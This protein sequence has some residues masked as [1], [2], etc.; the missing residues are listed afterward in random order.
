MEIYIE[1]LEEGFV[2][3]NHKRKV[4]KLVKSLYGLKQAPKQWHEKFDK[5]M[6][7]NDFRINEC[8]KCVYVKGTEKGYVIVCLYVDDML[9]I[10]SNNEFIKATKKMLTS[11]FEMKDMGVADVILEV[12]PLYPVRLFV[13]RLSAPLRDKF[14]LKNSESNSR[15]GSLLLLSKTRT[16]QTIRGANLYLTASGEEA[17][18]KGVHE[19]NFAPVAAVGSVRFYPKDKLAFAVVDGEPVAGEEE[20]SLEDGEMGLLL[21]YKPIVHNYSTR[22]FLFTR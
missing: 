2:A 9:I 20:G 1:Q 6:I 16:A 15:I 19:H 18:A 8:D 3:P 17:A 22:H 13:K 14:S 12:L 21:V 7:E 5:I 11:K 4:C 10:R